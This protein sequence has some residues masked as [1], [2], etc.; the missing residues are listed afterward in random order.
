MRR[1]NLGGV[2]ASSPAFRTEIATLRSQR[3]SHRSLRGA[4]FLASARNRL[5]NLGGGRGAWPRG[6]A[7]LRAAEIATPE[8]ALGTAEILRC[9]QNDK[10][11]GARNDKGEGARNDD[12]GEAR[13][14]NAAPQYVT[15]H[16]N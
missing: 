8:R 16:K 5:R 1:S 6:R 15:N 3:H 4:G 10:G 2:A 12:G 11:K 7:A 9:A 14:D 13:D